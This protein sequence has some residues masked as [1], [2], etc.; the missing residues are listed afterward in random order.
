MPAGFAQIDPKGE[1]AA[2]AAAVAT[3][4]GDAPLPKVIQS[5]MPAELIV[6]EGK[7]E[8][9]EI[10]GTD[11]LR[12]VSNT[13][14]PLFELEGHLL[15]PRV[16]PLVRDEAISTKGPWKFVPNLPDAFSKIP[17]DSEMADVRASVP[18]TVEAKSAALEALLPTRKSIATGAAPGREGELRRRAEVRADCGHAGVAR[19]RTAATT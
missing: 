7:P 4:V 17:A 3:P 16:G 6:T 10:P 15:L 12:Y 5:S 1:Q 9:E 19:G 2:I 8:L 11:G 14:S 13:D 18:G